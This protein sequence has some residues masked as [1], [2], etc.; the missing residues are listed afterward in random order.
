MYKKILLLVS[1]VT[2]L[3]SC[4]ESFKITGEIGETANGETVFLQKQ[5]NDGY[6]VLDS[7]VVKNG[8]FQFSGVQEIPVMAAITIDSQ[9]PNA[10]RPLFFV[11]ENGRMNALM[12]TISTISG[13]KL[14]DQFQNYMTDRRVFDS[15]IEML[16]QNYMTDYVAGSLTDTVFENLKK[17]FET[18]EAQIKA[19]TW[20]YVK[21]NSENVTGVFVF[22]QNSFLFTPVEQQNI[23]D[24]AGDFFKKN[25]MIKSLSQLLASMKNVAVGMPY[26]DIKME[27]PDGK[28]VSLSDY[29]GKGKYILID[30]WAAW[31]APCRRQMPEL[32]SLYKQFKSKPFEI[33]GVSFDTNEADWL[34]A[35][36]E[37]DM[38]WPQMCD[39][40]GWDS[41]AIMLYAIQGIPHTVLVSPDGVIIAKDLKGSDLT[42]KLQTL[43]K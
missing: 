4:S 15:R 36:K 31:C 11:L 40:K 26:L 23:I 9:D 28:T 14:N 1:I 27:N 5:E 6:I 43:L 7:A 3:V 39:L 8:T 22:L 32:V 20:D 25:Q 21:N 37:M 10:Y 17:Q 18:E 41:E 24:Q 33:V 30:F 2:A 12:D 42:K 34:S 29:I 35:I 16:S 13:T 38:T 19:L